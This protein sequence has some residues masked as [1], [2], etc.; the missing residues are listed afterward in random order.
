MEMN[1]LK[2]KKSKCNVLKISKTSINLNFKAMNLAT[3]Y[4]LY[5]K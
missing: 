1:F 5:I 2:G 3:I 4:F